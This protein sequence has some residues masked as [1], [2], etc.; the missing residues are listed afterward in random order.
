[1]QFLN[2]FFRNYVNKYTKDY[3]NCLARKGVKKLGLVIGSSTLRLLEVTV[4]SKTEIEI[5]AFALIYYAGDAELSTL[6]SKALADQAIAT[7]TV[8]IAL[9]QEQVVTRNFSVSSALSLIELDTFIE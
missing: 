7:R 9:K 3:N 6:L 8:S 2:C 5:S 4:F 1:M